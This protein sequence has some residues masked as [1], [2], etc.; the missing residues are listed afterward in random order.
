MKYL[1]TA[2]GTSACAL[3]ALLLAVTSILIPGD[4][5][6]QP[7][8]TPTDIPPDYLA[9][10]TYAAAP[11]PGCALTIPPPGP[12][13]VAVTAALRWLGTP[14][15]WGGGGLTG[16]TL[17]IAHGSSTIGFDCSGLT[18]YAWHQTG[19]T[20]PRI[21]A[22]QW[23]A[24]P[25]VP[26]GQEAPGDL[27]FFRSSTG[28]PTNPGHVGLILDA[29]HMIEAPRTGL[30]IR[31]TPWTTRHDLIGVARPTLRNLGVGTQER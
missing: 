18:R 9:H 31:I 4:G 3:I 5:P 29:Q 12:G 27:V 1:T 25:H 8:A 21:A 30:T 2:I 6:T 10:P 13:A 17:G 15:S 24:L 19:I 7:C 20:L 28:T 26:P 14:Y 16:P 11:D 22:D 23:H